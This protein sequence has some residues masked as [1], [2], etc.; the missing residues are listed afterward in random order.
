MQ[1]RECCWL[2]CKWIQLSNHLV[3]C[4][5]FPFYISA[6]EW[7][8]RLPGFEGLLELGEQ[9]HQARCLTQYM[10]WVFELYLSLFSYH[11]SQY[12]LSFLNFLNA[13]LKWVQEG[14]KNCSQSLL[15][16]SFSLIYYYSNFI[17]VSWRLILQLSVLLFHLI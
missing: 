8:L 2:A 10:N 17:I 15:L 4:F 7:L 14:I 3:H 16:P 11:S 12:F 9:L 5:I 1:C 13:W 6:K